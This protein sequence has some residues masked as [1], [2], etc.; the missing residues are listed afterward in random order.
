MRVLWRKKGFTLV[1]LIV[2]IAI[3]GILAAILLPVMVGLTTKA[4]VTS[5][6]NTAA[7]I[8]KSMNLL[9]LQADSN[10][11]GIVPSQEMKFDITAS[12]TGGVT[13][14]TCTAAP[15]GSYNNTNSS[16]MQWGS[17][18]TFTEGE[19][20]TGNTSGEKKICAS[21]S[22]RFPEIDVASVV[23]VLYSGNCSFVAFTRDTSTVLTASDYPT[24][25][26]GTPPANFSWDGDNA[27]ISPNGYI[28]GTAP[29]VGLG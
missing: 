4:R 6:N 23:V 14:W 19:D 25:T 28:I 21:L 24:V 3:I 5:A 26:N 27:G 16:G 20:M 22:E 2:V 17:A 12:T 29:V 10:H 9:L 15:A 11:F 7:S 8:Q 18:A 1:E 13:T